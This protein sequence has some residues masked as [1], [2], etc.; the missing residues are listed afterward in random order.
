[1]LVT[2]RSIVAAIVFV[3]G[4]ASA[5]ANYQQPDQAATPGAPDV[6]MDEARR[7]FYNGL[8]EEAA[9]LAET[10]RL[11]EAEGLAAYELRSSALLFQIRRALGDP[12]DKE[13]ALKECQR[14][15][16]LMTGF[17]ADIDAG[18]VVARAQLQRN[19]NDENARFFLGKLNLNYVWLQLGT[20]GRRTGWDEYWE[21]RRSL[22]TLLK[23]NPNHVR[24]RVARAW[25]DYIVDT[26]MPWGTAWLLGGGNKKRGLKTVQD[27][28]AAD[29]NFYDRIEATFALWDMQVREKNY[30]EA[31]VAAQQIAREFP[32]NRDVARFLETHGE[33]VKP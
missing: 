19:P 16:G 28:A 20:L 33:L 8:Y 6:S 24:G 25:I 5:H 32:A 15:P 4:V 1:M 31:A 21:A 14:C 17:R 7:L 18:R 13:K 9:A 29:L 3:L 23:Q 30:K 27:A 11:S 2:N 22:D 12:K 26:R 10:M